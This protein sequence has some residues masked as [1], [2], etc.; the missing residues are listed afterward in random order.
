MCCTYPPPPPIYCTVPTLI[1]RY[2]PTYS[3]GNAM[4]FVFLLLFRCLCL[5][6]FFPFFVV[7]VVVVVLFIFILSNFLSSFVCFISFR[8][9]CELFFFLCVYMFV[10][11]NIK[12]IYIYVNPSFPIL[13]SFRSNFYLYY[14]CTVII[15]SKKFLSIYLVRCAH[16]SFNDWLSIPDIVSNCTFFVF[17]SIGIIGYL[18]MADSK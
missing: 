5:Y 9:M 10:W 1:G 11:Y 6:F 3:K 4:C 13:L 16:Y 7:V 12:Y 2:L 18:L 14:P 15:L 17:I 8:S